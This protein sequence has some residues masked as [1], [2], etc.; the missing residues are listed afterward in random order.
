MIRRRDTLE[1]VLS[2]VEAHVLTDVSTVVVCRDWW[3]KLS[4][5]EQD[6]YRHRSE[7]VGID[8]RAD[9]WL[10]SH[11]VEVRGED[12]GPGLSTERPM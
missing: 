9:D 1:Q 4:S 10:S 5:T 2:E 8:L 7:Q 6:A 12:E 11:F 3:E